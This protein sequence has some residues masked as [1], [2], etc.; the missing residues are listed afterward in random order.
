MEPHFGEMIVRGIIFKSRANTSLWK[1]NHQQTNRALRC[2][3]SNLLNIADRQM[4]KCKR[5]PKKN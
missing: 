1:L 5:K 3:L 2:A 4:E